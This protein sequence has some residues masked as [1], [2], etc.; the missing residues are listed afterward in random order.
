MGNLVK[1]SEADLKR[2]QQKNLEIAKYIAEFCKDH[3]LKVYLFA[4]TCLGAVRQ[5]GFIPWDDDFDMVMPAPDYKKL[6]QIWDSEADTERYSLCVQSREYNDHHLSDS[7]RDNHTTFITTASVETDTNQGV[8]IDF[9]CF[10][11]AAKTKIGRAFQLV[12]ACGATL[13][14]AGRLPNRQSKLV[15]TLS[16]LLLGIFRGDGVRYHIWK[17]LEDLA[18]L[19]DKDYENAKYVK[20][21]SMFP[22]I[23]WLYPKEWFDEAV[24]VP[25]EDTKLPIAKGSKRYLK[26]RYGNYMEYPPVEERHPEHKIVFM[27]L[28]APYTKY[29]GVKYYV[30]HDSQPTKPT[31]TKGGRKGKTAKSV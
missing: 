5:R 7:V 10:H 20:E 17:F 13:F 31:R 25:F 1:L 29:R 3:G 11:A 24:Y 15:Y 9:G 22:Y 27:D 8:A 12:C 6:L 19:P 30:G 2:L 21:F 18:T 14:K 4:G 26:K 16:K 28:D 23:T